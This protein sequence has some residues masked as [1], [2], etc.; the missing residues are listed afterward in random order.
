MAIKGKGKTRGK[1]A[2]APAPRPVLVTRKPPIYRRRWVVA[3]IAAVVVL[4]LALAVFTAVR[5]HSRSALLARERG[6]ISQFTT[7]VTSALPNDSSTA[8][9]STVFLFPQLATEMDNLSKGT[10]KPADSLTT[11]G[12][13]A[14]SAKRAAD[15]IQAIRTTT[16]VPTEFN[17][18]GI[19]L[20]GRGLMQAELL[21]AQFLIVQSFQS[22]QQAFALWAQAT[23]ATGD[24][25]KALIDQVNQVASSAQVLFSRGWTKV[26]QVR[27]QLGFSPI[28][29]IQ[30]Q[31]P[32]VPTP[33]A[34]ASPTTSS[35]PPTSPSPGASPTTSP[36][37][38]PAPTTSATTSA[39]PTG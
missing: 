19:D 22:Y 7:D 30:S 25:Q 23:S 3:A 32:V 31:N 34:T 9:G 21:D 20:R 12:Q 18:G 2:V 5:S 8:G 24:A 26:V 35:T 38:S 28:T 4:G 16:L 27:G 6:A 15:Q 33:T 14:A 36:T 37:T 29:Q 39:S 17:V 13:Y 10:T 11:E 1:R